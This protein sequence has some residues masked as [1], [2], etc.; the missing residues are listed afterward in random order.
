MSKKK[1]T[2]KKIARKETIELEEKEKKPLDEAQQ[3]PVEGETAQQAQQPELAEPT[4]LE[5]LQ[6]EY[7]DLNDRYLRVLAE[8]DNFRRRSAKER[9]SIYPEAK[10]SVLT[11]FLPVLDNFSRAMEAPTTDP[12]FKKGMEMICTAYQECFVKQGVEEIGA[13]GET[14]DPQLHNAVMH[15]EDET[16]EEG[17]VC[18]VFQKGYRLGDKVLRYAMVKVAN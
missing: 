2:K 12:E 17:V 9:E 16:L 10:A 3:T 14:F 1:R 4:E 5:K 7:A 13:V 6:Q 15:V 11:A 18:E 8:Y